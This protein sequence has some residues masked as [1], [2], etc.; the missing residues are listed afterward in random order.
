ML[1]PG[2]RLGRRL[3]SGLSLVELMVGVTIGLM[4]VAAA[5]VLMTGQL[6]ENRRLLLETQLQQDLR[7]AADII[8][9]DLRRAG[10]LNQGTALGTIW[11]PGASGAILNPMSGSLAVG[12]DRVDFNYDPGPGISGPFGFRLN[13]STGVLE[14]RLSGSGWQD[15]TDGNV[16]R[17]TSF[18]ITP[19]PPVLAGQVLPPPALPP[20]EIPCPY[21]CASGDTT[22]W[23]RVQV[24]DL[25]FNITAVARRD[26]SVQRSVGGRVRLRNEWIEFRPPPAAGWVGICPPAVS[27]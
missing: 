13:S 9:R 16:M 20:V 23:P 22:C 19:E 11:Y 18:T 15:L 3:Q 26:P 24:R 1:M 10:T 5:T 25:V 12:T 7:A 8:A 21:L 6:S 4:V 2:Q 17:V 27:P 14:T